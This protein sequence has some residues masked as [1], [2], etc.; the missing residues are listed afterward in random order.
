MIRKILIGSAV[1]FALLSYCPAAQANLIWAWS[2]G[3]GFSAQAEV[4]LVNPHQLQIVVENTST[5]WPSAVPVDSANQLLTS[6][7]FDLPVG[8]YIVGGSAYLGPNARTIGFD[9]LDVQ[10]TEGGNVSAE[11][12]YSNV[13]YKINLGRN[14]ITAMQS[15]STRFTAGGNLDGPNGLNGPQGGLVANPML[16]SLGGLGAIEGPVRFNVCLSGNVALADIEPGAIEFGSDAAFAPPVAVPE[17]A[18]LALLAAGGATF[19]GAWIRRKRAT[20]A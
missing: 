14:V 17:P 19:G 4:S 20:R 10:L 9:E 3:D 13:G 8:L 6:V 15:Q 11:W 7:S 12:G 18:T 1:V 5:F 2:T 16:T